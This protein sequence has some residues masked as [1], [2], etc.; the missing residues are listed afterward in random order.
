MRGVDH[1]PGPAPRLVVPYRAVPLRVRVRRAAF[2]HFPLAELETV[3][4]NE[5]KRLRRG[6]ARVTRELFQPAP[7]GKGKGKR[8]RHSVLRS[9]RLSLPSV[10]P[11]LEN[12]HI[13]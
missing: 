9:E 11:G 13:G 7:L 10:R 6:A 4:Q 12:T 1:L 3:P 5:A 2:A 8:L